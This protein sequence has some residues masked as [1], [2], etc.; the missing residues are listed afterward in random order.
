MLPLLIAVAVVLPAL[1]RGQLPSSSCTAADGRQDTVQFARFDLNNVGDVGN[2]EPFV[3]FTVCGCHDL[4]RN[5]AGCI[6]F[7]YEPKTVSGDCYLKRPSTIPPGSRTIFKAFPNTIIDGYFSRPNP[8]QTFPDISQCLQECIRQ[9]A[10]CNYISYGPGGACGLE[11]GVVEG[12]KGS[13]GLIFLGQAPPPS[14]PSS[15]SSPALPNSPSQPSSS[16]GPSPSSNS[17]GNTATSQANPSSSAPSSLGTLATTIFTTDGPGSNDPR[18]TRPKSTGKP[19]PTAVDPSSSSG[20]GDADGSSFLPVVLKVGGAIIG[21]CIV[22]GVAVVALYRRD[23]GRRDAKRAEKS[24]SLEPAQG[25][26]QLEA[27]SNEAQDAEN[28]GDPEPTPTDL[29]AAAPKTTL[30]STPNPNPDPKTTSSSLFD[31]LQQAPRS[32]KRAVVGYY[33]RQASSSSQD[34]VPDSPTDATEPVLPVLASE[35]APIRSEPVSSSRSPSPSSD[36][37]VTAPSKISVWSVEQVSAA[38]IQAGASG[39]AVEVLKENNVNG[40]GLL[41]IDHPSLLDMGFETFDADAL[42]RVIGVVRAGEGLVEDGAAAPP[43]Y[44]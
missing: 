38:L 9:G 11:R 42:L 40:F 37:P 1:V 20:T 43:T 6:G 2:A 4:C 31:V 22:V 33:G 32:R 39:E 27:G 29:A 23:K 8:Q 19:N 12:S 34:I 21:V 41:V 44:S 16:S 36:G 17:G 3:Q 5:L 35:T 7:V 14:L 28:R 15:P 18:T 26:T 10:N 30:F 13:F 24:S 25:S